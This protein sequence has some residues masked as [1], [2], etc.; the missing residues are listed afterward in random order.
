MNKDLEDWVGRVR[1]RARQ[2]WRFAWQHIFVV[3]Q[4]GTVLSQRFIVGFDT[5]RI[6]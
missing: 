3:V 6:F 2:R 4:L 5:G 1:V